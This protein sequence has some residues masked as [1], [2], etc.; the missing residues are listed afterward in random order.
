[1]CVCSAELKQFPCFSRKY[2]TQNIRANYIK[3]IL[4]WIW[5]T[6][7]LMLP[8]FLLPSVVT[9]AIVVRLFTWWELNTKKQF[10]Q[11]LHFA[12]LMRAVSWWARYTLWLMMADVKFS[13]H[14]KYI[15]FWA[16]EYKFC[17]ICVLCRV[18]YYCIVTG[19]QVGKIKRNLEWSY[20]G[21]YLI[22]V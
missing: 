20:A 9:E 22:K 3:G 13:V 18:T 8:S 11:C 17:S 14:N 2:R 6:H 15:R 12:C 7:A 4:R 1:M 5:L 21:I 16:K 10:S 19:W